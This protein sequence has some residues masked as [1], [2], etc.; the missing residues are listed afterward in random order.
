MYK[1]R[2]SFLRNTIVIIDILIT[3]IAY[4]IAFYIRAFNFYG[5]LREL[6]NFW[7]YT[8]VVLLVVLLWPFVL[9]LTGNYEF[10]LKENFAFTVFS[11]FKAIVIG[12]MII[13]ALFYFRQ[14]IGLSRFFLLL[15][16]ALNFL[17]LCIERYIIRTV[18]LSPVFIERETTRVLV[19]GTGST[20]QYFVNYVNNHPEMEMDIIGHLKYNNHNDT[21]KHEAN[22]I[23]EHSK[24]IERNKYNEFNKRCEINNRILGTVEDIED[25]VIEYVVDE[26]VFASHAKDICEFE[27]YV[28]LCEKIGITVDIIVDIKKLKY[29][30][31]RTSFMG[32]MP[33][34]TY[35]TVSLS[36]NQLFIKRV[37]D[38]IGGVI[39]I[40]FTAAALM[41]IAPAILI[42]SRGPVFFAQDRMG[43]N[44]RVFKCYKLRT[45]YPGSDEKKEE[46]KNLSIM[47]G[48][49]FKIK[50]DPRVT[51][52][53]RILRRISLDETPQFW[54]V[55]KGDMSLVGTRPPT[56]DEVEQYKLHHFRRL[57][58]K[59]G[60]TGLWQVKG[61]NTVKSF[62]KIVKFDIEY[63]DNWSFWLDLR[64]MLQTIWAI[65]KSN[66]NY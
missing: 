3:L 65:I 31:G 59:P 46:L 14:D 42:E 27:S 8:W 7:H 37:M 48:A 16:A 22:R 2:V 23:Q 51:K 30:K 58:I 24:T 45:M 15:F 10:K 6:S 11:I 26:V 61:R 43:K 33:I 57:S 36:Q 63:I 25:I 47:Q 39:G 4:Y 21:E 44:G 13:S 18:I 9:Y 32:E 1:E 50:N 55:L 41:F 49:I 5:I 52:V 40:A 34:L 12:V 60:I 38:V 64:I 62:E 28:K 54:N 19:V 53:G 35:Y 29:S 17:L 20:A 56:L 66:G